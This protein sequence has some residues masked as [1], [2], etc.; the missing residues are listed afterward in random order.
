M[1]VRCTTG[2]AWWHVVVKNDG[3]FVEFWVNRI[4][5]VCNAKDKKLKIKIRVLKKV[6]RFKVG[7]N[8]P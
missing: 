8:G 2:I 7:A 1:S 3:S 5:Q 6:R 4:M